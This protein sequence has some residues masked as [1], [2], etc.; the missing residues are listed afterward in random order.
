MNDLKE[1]KPQGGGGGLAVAVGSRGGS[2]QTL[3]PGEKR[4]KAMSQP[5]VTH[6]GTK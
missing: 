1:K 2:R 6:Q 4:R 3:D 5:R